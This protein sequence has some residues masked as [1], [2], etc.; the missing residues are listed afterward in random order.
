MGHDL[1][2]FK[3]EIKARN[4]LY[5]RRLSAVD[6]TQRKARLRR[7]GGDF[8]EKIFSFVSCSRFSL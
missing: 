6:Y 3:T 5:D 4:Y 7:F 1:A 8:R 2:V